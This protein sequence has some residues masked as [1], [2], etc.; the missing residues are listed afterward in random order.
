MMNLKNDREALELA[1]RI[2]SEDEDRRRQMDSML[3]DRSWIETAKFAA[4]C[5]QGASL[6][7][8]P[9]ELSPADVREE[10]G[11]VPSARLLQKMLDRGISKYHPDPLKA[12]KEA[13]GREGSPTR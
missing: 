2:A 9:W 8:K 11:D 10:D 13:D 6:N 7:L 4:S 1:M 3:K 12:L 5:C